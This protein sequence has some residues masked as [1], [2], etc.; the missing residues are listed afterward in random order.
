MTDTELAL[1]SGVL[2]H[3]HCHPSKLDPG[4]DLL[5]ALR[6]K[7]SEAE[8]IRTAVSDAVKT[9]VGASSTLRIIKPTT[10]LED[11]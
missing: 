9:G 3:Y 2:G 10:A 11:E 6:L 8:R 4:T 5:D 1:F 7:W